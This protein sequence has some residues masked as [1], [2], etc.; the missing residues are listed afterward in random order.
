MTIIDRWATVWNVSPAAVRDLKRMM[1]ADDGFVVLHVP[2]TSE[3]PL[4]SEA[5]QQSLVRLEAAKMGVRLFRNNSGAFCDENGRMVRFGLGNDSKQVNEVFKS[6][7]LMSWRPV[8]IRPDM[9]GMTIGQFCAREM[10]HEGWKY[11]L[12]D[13]HEVA[14][15][16]FIRLA[17]ADGCDA[18]FA[19]GPGSL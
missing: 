5:R 6:P 7:D 17:I 15:F 16:N 18:A 14:Q 2:S 3:A 12:A 9:V 11:N 19:T 1:G 4:G 8:V 13:A 10:K